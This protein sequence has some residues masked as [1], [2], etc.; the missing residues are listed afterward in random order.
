VRG[1]LGKLRHLLSKPA[2]SSLNDIDRKLA[3]YLSH[4]GGFFIEA[5]ANDGYTQSNTFFLEKKLGWSGVLVEGIPELHARCAKLRKRST[6]VNC[7]LVSDDFEGESVTMHFA[8]L[9]SVVDGSLKTPDAQ[10]NHLALGRDVQKLTTSYSVE[11]PARTLAAVLQGLGKIPPIDLLSLDVEGYELD[12]LKGADLG[13]FR[14]RYILVEAR[15]FD[16]VD[17]F[18]RGN[19]YLLVEQF[20]VHDYLYRSS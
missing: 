7:A 18:L 13:R 3:R 8:N 14:P 5:G 4:R 19:G 1:I 11:V 2:R 6:V 12:V 10:A 17:A 15:F 20:S 9:M 16:E